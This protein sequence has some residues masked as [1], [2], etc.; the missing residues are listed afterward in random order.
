MEGFEAADEALESRR[1]GRKGIG[2][3]DAGHK[4]GVF[5]V[6]V[7]EINV[8]GDHSWGKRLSDLRVHSEHLLVTFKEQ[9]EAD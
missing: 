7:I 3:V 2:S 4:V 5:G 6:V 1:V 8:V 9:L